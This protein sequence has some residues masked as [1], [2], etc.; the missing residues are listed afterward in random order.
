MF[1]RITCKPLAGVDRSQLPAG[2]RPRGGAAAAAR[3]ARRS[4]RRQ[5]GAAA[6]ARRR[7]RMLPSVMPR[8]RRPSPDEILRPVK[9]WFIAADAAARRSSPTSLPLSGVALALR[10]DFLAL[11]L[12]YWCIQEPRYV[13]VGVAWLRR[14]RDGRRRRAR[15]SASTRSPMRCSPTPPSTSAAAC[16]ASRCGSRRRR[17]R[18]CSVLC[19]ALVLLVRVVG[20]APL[21]R[22]T[23]AVPPL[24][25][26]LL[27]PLLSVLLQWP[28][29]PPRSPANADRR[30]AHGPP[31]LQLA[32]RYGAVARLRRAGAAQSP[33]ASC[34][35][36]RRRLG[37][38][39]RARRWSRSAGCSRA[40][41]TCR[42]SQHDHY[43][44]LAETNRIAI[45][46]I[47]PNRGVITDRNG[48]VLAQSYS[49]Y[50][51]EITPARVK[52]LDATI[53]ALAD[54]R[55]RHA[56]RPQALPQAARGIE[57]LREPAAAHAA[58]RRGSRALR[59]QPLPLSR[60]RDQGAAVPPVP[61]RR[62]RVARR[63]L[64]RPHQRPRRRAHRRVGR[65][66]QLQGL[67]LHRQG[68]HRAL[69]RA[70]AARHDRRR[71]GRGRRRRPR[72]AHAVA[73]AADLRQQPRAVARHQAAAGRRGGVRR[74]P[75]RAGGDRSHHR[76][77]ARVRVQARLR[78]QPVRRRHRLRELGGAQRLA[79]QAAAQPAAA[80]RVSA[81]LDDQAVPGARRAHVGQAH[82]GADDLRSRA[83]SSSRAGASLP[84]RQARRP[85]HGR[86]VQ[87]DRRVLR[88]VLLHARQRDRHRRHRALPVAARLRPQ[89]RHRHRGRAAPACCRRANGSAQRF[90]GKNYRE[91]HR[92]WYLGDTHL[93]RHRPGLQR[94]HADAARARD[95]DDRQRRRRATRRTS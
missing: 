23:Y 21:P 43:Q 75:R 91:E 88:H 53:D 17:S 38:R 12:L 25:G 57:E 19:A 59:R 24:V 18:C 63:R 10:P 95:R 35:L 48:V 7:M 6:R 66:G 74:P 34:F 52:N 33:S 46:P 42:S 70:R 37:D 4:R 1:A 16:C 2:A 61:V 28:Q 80:R 40:S 5:E 58:D 39:R 82:A 71:G 30:L 3:R 60:R 90:A 8:S 83:T 62:A 11:V 22:W 15:C 20:G 44:T 89:D 73:H 41:S 67:R 65:D 77:R 54:D 81:G 32:A 27:W 49:A 51:L 72:G 9:P 68:R 78:S 85:R 84:R 93:G 45:V 29:R 26:A 94:V 86:H 36:F 55:R 14:A 69:V 76:R 47:V 92:K 50:T 13:G 56:A 64:H 87:V 79:R 31:P